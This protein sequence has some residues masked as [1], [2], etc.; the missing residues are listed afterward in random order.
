MIT[1]IITIEKNNKDSKGNNSNSSN[2][3]NNKSFGN[4]YSDRGYDWSYVQ[5]TQAF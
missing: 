2:N 5:L 4:D 3:D 1:V